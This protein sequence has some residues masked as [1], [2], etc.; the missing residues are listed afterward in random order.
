MM[1]SA[2]VLWT[3]LSRV[4]H[5]VGRDGH[6]LGRRPMHADR[7]LKRQQRTRQQ[8]GGP[9]THGMSLAFVRWLL[10]WA[11]QR[12]I[13]VIAALPSRWEWDTTPFRTSGLSPAPDHAAE[14][15]EY[16]RPPRIV[17]NLMRILR[18][19]RGASALCTAC[20]SQ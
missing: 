14:A 16:S 3:G 6:G 7:E 1:L 2:R 18:Y 20:R 12:V 4:R 19:A 10:R 8:A 13:R 15:P 17:V 9:T 11:S 5:G